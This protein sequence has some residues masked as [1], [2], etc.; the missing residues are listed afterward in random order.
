MTLKDEILA[1]SFDLQ[2]RDDG[3]IAAALS[4]GRT[5]LVSTMIGFGRILDALGPTDGATVLDTLESI[6]A[7]NSA[8]KWAWYLLERGELDVSLASVRGQ[9]DALATA[10][11][12]TQTQADAIKDLAVQVDV[13]TANDVAHALEGI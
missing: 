6:K 11:A 1:G 12:M 3:A 10:G 4:V 5:K 8:L 13:V 2:N 7:S 9:I